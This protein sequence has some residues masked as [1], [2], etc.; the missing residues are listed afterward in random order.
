MSERVL[1]VTQAASG[2]VSAYTGAL[3]RFQARNGYDVAVACPPNTPLSMAVDALETV[4]WFEWNAQR[5]PS[6]RLIPEVAF[7]RRIIRIVDPHVVHLHSAKAGLAG[8]L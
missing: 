2:G 3:I 8:R 1:H 6:L 7:L 5:S 4:R